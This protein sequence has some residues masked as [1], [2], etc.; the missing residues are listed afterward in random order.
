MRLIDSNEL[1]KRTVCFVCERDREGLFVDTRKD[2]FPIGKTALDGR[3]YVCARCV[4]HMAEVSGFV[5]PEDASD[6][7]N[8]A[9]ARIEMLE[10]ELESAQARNEA[11]STVKD[12]IARLS[13]LEPESEQPAPVKPAPEKPAPVN[14][15]LAMEASFLTDEPKIGVLEEEPKKPAVKPKVEK[16]KVY[17]SAKS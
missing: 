1:R 12:A 3:K 4:Q 5:S 7:A 8:T 15:A 10:I 13:A 11:L 6:R 14:S 2:F 9:G 17:G 16:A